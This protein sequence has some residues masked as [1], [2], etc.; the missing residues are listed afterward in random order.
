VIEAA[1][2]THER[3]VRSRTYQRVLRGVREWLVAPI[4]AA[5]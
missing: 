4:D 5:I 1:R 2:R 3:F